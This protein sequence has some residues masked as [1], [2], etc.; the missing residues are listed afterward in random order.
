MDVEIA[1][2]LN[3]VHILKPFL[4]PEGLENLKI[5]FIENDPWG[6]V[7]EKNENSA[8]CNSMMHLRDKRLFYFTT[9]STILSRADIHKLNTTNDIKFVSDMLKWWLN[10]QMI[11]WDDSISF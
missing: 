8:L 6:V 3:M 1:T 5:G 10:I 11:L 2:I 7:C 4:E 9:L